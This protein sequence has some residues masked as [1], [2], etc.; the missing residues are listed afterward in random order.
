[1]TSLILLIFLLF[2]LFLS[3][4]LFVLGLISPK[5]SLF[6]R[7]KKSR[8]ASSLIYG[9]LFVI[10][11]FSIG[12][13]FSE[14]KILEEASGFLNNAEKLADK[15]DFAGAVKLYTKAVNLKLDTTDENQKHLL[16]EAYRERC[17][18]YVKLKNYKLADND[19]ASYLKLEPHF[20]NISIRLEDY[21]RFELTKKTD[22]HSAVEVYS[23]LVKYEPTNAIFLTQ[24]GLNKIMLTNDKS[25]GLVDIDRAIEINNKCGYAYKVRALFTKSCEDYIMAKSLGEDVSIL[26]FTCK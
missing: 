22:Y 2:L 26:G 20:Y 9:L 11:F 13:Y 4:I 15:Q 1:M 12:I 10:T 25:T 21:V 24:L 16:A 18:S 14:D 8:I 19:M 17:I 6:W 3:A 23:L 5:I 7:K